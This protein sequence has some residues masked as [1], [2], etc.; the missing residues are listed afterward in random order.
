MDL[1]SKQSKNTLLLIEPRIN[2]YIFNILKRALNVLKDDWNYVFYCGK[3]CE[4]YWKKILPPIIELRELDVDNL[5]G[6][7]Y[8]NLCKSRSL[9][10]SLYGDFVL[11]IQLDAWIQNDPPYTIDYFINLNKSYIGGNMDYDWGGLLQDVPIKNFNGGLSLRKREDM[12]RIIDN[13]PSTDDLMEDVYFTMGCYKLGLSVGDD[14]P[15][16]HFAVHSIFKSRCFGYHNLY[17]SPTKLVM[18]HRP[19]LKILNPH[20]VLSTKID[21]EQRTK[22]SKNKIMHVDNKN[23]KLTKIYNIVN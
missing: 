23:N 9:W 21:L 18:L 15:S 13:I 16:S 6:V 7:T 12:I 17:D 3:G 14:K 11:T 4:N 19:Y 1:T 22:N 5:N 20:M 8:S 2:M 10:D